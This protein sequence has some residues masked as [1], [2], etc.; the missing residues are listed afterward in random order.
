MKWKGTG[1]RGETVAF[2]TPEFKTEAEE[3]EW[4]DAHSDMLSGI[5]I[6]HGKRVTDKTK[7]VTIRLPEHDILRA[8][9]I[10]R[11]EGIKYQPLLKTLLHDA[12]VRY[13][14]RR[15]AG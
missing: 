15:K 11:R 3:A 8:K 9:E 5:L 13:G 14:R 12:L 2:E 1:R 10:A 4:W 7:S 6:K